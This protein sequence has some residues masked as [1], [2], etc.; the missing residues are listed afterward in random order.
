VGEVVL[1]I[2]EWLA[3]IS[4]SEYMERFAEN[5]IDISVLGNLTDQD[6]KDIGVLLGHRR[7]M[8]AAVAE[9]SDAALPAPHSQPETRAQ[10][11]AE[12]RQLTVMFCDI[13]GST[14]LSEGLD[15]EDYRTVIGAYRRCCA[16]L[17]ERNGGF[18]AKFIGDGVLAYF[19][20]PHAHELDAEHSVR[21]AL[22]L[23]ETVPKLTTPASAPLQVRI[24][25]ATGLVV[26]GDLVS[27]SAAEEHAVVGDTPNLAARLQ[28]LAEPGTVLI[29]S[30]TRRLTGGLFDYRDL[31]AVALKGFAGKVSA[32]QPLGES[33]VESRF[34]ALRVRTTQLVGRGEEIDLL[35]RWWE[36]AKRGEGKVVLLAGE[37]GIGKSR[38]AE[39]ILERLSGAPHSHLRYFCSPYHQDSPFYPFI[40]RLERV[41]GFRP[42]DMDEERLAKLEAL[43]GV[44]PNDFDEVV[45]L[46]AGLLS[47]PTIDRY[48][49]LNLSPQ[50]RKEKTL[51]LLLRQVEELAARQPA[52]MVIEDAHWA[53]PTSLELIELIVEHAPRL[54]LLTIVTFRPEFAAPWIGRPHVLLMSLSRLR[55]ELSTEMITHLTGGK[56]L[57][58]EIT[59]QIIDRTDGVPLFIEELTK[60]V[61]ESGLLVESG[62]RYEA[63]GPTAPI[64]IPTSLQASL[65]ARLD[66]LAP[67]RGV[68]QIAAALG[69]R[70][71]YELISAVAAIPRKQ[72]DDAL[73]ALVH[74]ELIFQNGAGLDAEYTFKHALLQDAAYGTMLRS[75]RQLLHARIAKTL[76]DHFPE[77][78]ANQPPV[79]ALH[80][81]AARLTQKATVFWLKA[82]QQALARGAMSEAAVHLQRGLEVLAGLPDDPWRRQHELDLQIALRTA[83][84]ATKSLAAPAVG[85]IL[86]RAR[87]LAEQVDQPTYLVPLFSGQWAFH[88]VRSEHRLALQLGEQ[89]ERIGEA[90]NDATTQWVGRVLV[91]QTRLFLGELIAARTLLE[92][93]NDI[94]DSTYHAGD[95]LR[96][97]EA[98]LYVSMLA[99]L[100]LTLAYLGYLDQA[101]SRRDEAL[102]QARRFPNSP[103][104][105]NALAFACLL[106]SIIRSPDMQAH[107]EELFTLSTEHGFPFFLGVATTF[108]G[109][110]LTEL[111]KA[112]EGL[113][114]V[115]H[116]VAAMRASGAVISMS[117]ALAE[118]S[119]AHA[120][121]DQPGEGLDRLAEAAQIAE[122]TEQQIDEP[123]VYRLRGYLLDVALDSG[124]AERS[125]H[126][127]LAVA[128]SQSAKLMELR[129]SVNLAHLW[130]K[131]GKRDEARDL[132]ATIYN[133]FTEG[134][135]T[136]ILDEAKTLLEELAQ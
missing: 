125:Y 95:S 109:A 59:D 5:G 134:F 121:L 14:A 94:S 93:C 99:H 117:H 81:A 104:L 50:K 40:T 51:Q 133:W 63:A 28:A 36:Q 65:L 69:R 126:Q 86:T 3:S 68:A 85:E 47:V 39:T 1:T 98:H 112:R 13:V 83:V 7:K 77:I 127:A 9:F 19:G 24:G 130:R 57:P 75:Q 84:A 88:R 120:K 53:D 132:L 10:S 22:A 131:Q 4:M 17:V 42:E 25:I 118:A 103:T 135:G 62:D 100:A 89:L 113:A 11:E 58:K 76:E 8:L 74:S 54:S 80:C 32:W 41:A 91:G 92:R 73:A 119:V 129:A 48:P 78:V 49:S 106:G 110:S 108:R 55:H 87:A 30:S 33:A 136:P 123:E 6:L 35:L 71:S 79:L 26:V 72:L 96:S 27:A 105:A 31:D 52:L 20:Y 64:A 122:T 23:V 56:V 101:R 70:F 66:R 82:G 61:L 60:T 111:G 34:E 97:E 15:P 102:A 90:R 114:L 46:L 116:G 37:P 107:A 21:A 128:R 12:R 44:A 2:G 16:E 43:L 115:E 67:A 38:I 29:S 45:P 18:V 124:A